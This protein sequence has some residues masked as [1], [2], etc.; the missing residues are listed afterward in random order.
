MNITE[1]ILQQ[2]KALVR[3]IEALGTIEP[4]RPVEKAMVWLLLQAYRQRLR[5]IVEGQ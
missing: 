5:G 4:T 1:K 3:A 2:G